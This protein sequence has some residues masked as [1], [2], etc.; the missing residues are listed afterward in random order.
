MT[1]RLNIGVVRLSRLIT[2]QITG[3]MIQ[4]LK[5]PKGIMPVPR[6]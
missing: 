4:T 1:R 6:A 2:E 3:P 5:W